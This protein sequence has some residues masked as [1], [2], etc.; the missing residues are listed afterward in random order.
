MGRNRLYHTLLVGLGIAA[1]VSAGVGYWNYRQDLQKAQERVA[2]GS[3]IAETACGPIEYG[4]M[5]SGDPVLM[6]HG[7]GGGYDQ[8]LSLAETFIGEEYHSITPSRFGYLRT[9]LP[10]DASIAAQTEAHACL[11]DALDIPR[12]IVMGAS[13]GAP[14]SL[15]FALQHP[16]RVSA[17]ILLVPGLYA[18]SVQASETPHFP[19]YIYDALM[20]TNL[21]FWLWM[22]AAPSSVIT[23][24]LATPPEVQARMTPADRER[25]YSF[26][27]TILPVDSRRAGILNDAHVVPSQGRFPLEEVRVPTLVISARDDLYNTYPAAEYTA[28]HIPGARFVGYE[29]G[30]HALAGHEKEVR[31]EIMRFIGQHPPPGR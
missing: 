13:A 23:T 30:G 24:L 5:G 19:E 20:S 16:E 7:A 22:R 21:P 9:P 28:R 11:L 18:P 1:G 14:S 10:E 6:V 17:L 29:E 31:S 12:T 2:S 25:I 15:Q 26:M 4:T 8:G 27:Q 3:H